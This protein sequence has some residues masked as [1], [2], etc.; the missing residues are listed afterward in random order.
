[1]FF[2][3]SLS[4]K[5][6]QNDHIKSKHECYYI[7]G[8]FLSPV[9]FLV[10]LKTVFIIYIYVDI[11]QRDTW[12]AVYIAWGTGQGLGGC[13]DM[14]PERGQGLGGTWQCL[15]RWRPVPGT[16]THNASKYI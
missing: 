6:E 4:F 3:P 5:M 7:K 11:P 16:Y 1:M 15:Q 8:S 2:A 13:L 10:L 14:P 12:G 9:D